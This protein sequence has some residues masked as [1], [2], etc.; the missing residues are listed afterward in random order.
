VSGI[1]G[2]YNLD[3]RPV[4]DADLERMVAAMRR[5]G[6]DTSGMWSEGHVGLGHCMLRTNPESRYEISPLTDYSRD[7]VI[8]ADVRLDN[9]LELADELKLTRDRLLSTSDSE[10]ILI[11]Y[12]HWGENCPNRLLGDFSFAIWDRRKR[13]LFCA[14]D[15]FG[16]KPF[17]YYLSDLVF[18]FGSEVNALLSLPRIPCR[19]NEERIA[20]YIVQQLEGI[21]KTCTFYRDIFR[22][23][24]AHI[25]IVTGVKHM[26]RSYWS[27]NPHRKMHLRSDRD[28]AE[29]FRSI[30][31]E[32]VRCRLR[33]A[34]VVGSMLSGGIDSASIVALAHEVMP[35]HNDGPLQT[36]SAVSADEANCRETHFVNMILRQRDSGAHTVRSNQL[37]G[38]VRDMTYLL[39]ETTDP[40]DNWMAV[41]QTMYIAARNRGV[42]VLLDGVDGDLVASLNDGYVAYLLRRGKW[43]LAI[44]EAIGISRFYQ[45]EYSPLG[46]LYENIRRAFAPKWLRQVRHNFRRNVL[47]RSVNDISINTDFAR[48]I[49]LQHRLDA[50]SRHSPIV[51][52]LAE[53]HTNCINHPYS[54]VAFERYDRVASTYSVEP[55]HPL[56]DKRVVEFCV[57][58]PWHQKRYCGWTKVVLRRAMDSDLPREVLWR[59][60]REHLGWDFICCWLALEHKLLEEALAGD[61]RE[62]AEYLNVENVRTAYRRYLSGGKLEDDEE[63]LWR[64]VTLFF[65]LRRN[66]K[67]K[68]SFH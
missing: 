29:G 27:L 61:L 19:I 67:R 54:V 30:L 50:L 1:A 13:Y 15:H 4:N 7:L 41:P 16:I 38:Y 14:R 33:H 26:L 39:L 51:N 21:D 48:R 62:L 68:K 40:F 17:Y 24:P 10:L 52:T 49:G 28:Y 35:G 59:R 5:R 3:G 42:K 57:S 65:W 55:R 2:V 11:A 37:S 60:G 25:V 47:R 20:D 6:P 8:T 45:H 46:L 32:A 56:F 43:K 23:P 63:M 31:G 58:L 9:R 53:E 22:L 66:S 18:A 44:T 12:E 36:F 64:A 34:S